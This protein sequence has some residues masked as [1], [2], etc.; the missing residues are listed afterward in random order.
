MLTIL[1]PQLEL[2]E[3]CFPLP[4]PPTVESFEGFATTLRHS[5][6]CVKMKG[7]AVKTQRLVSQ[8][9]RWLS[10]VTCYQCQFSPWTLLQ[11][12]V[13][14]DTKHFTNNGKLTFIAFVQAGQDLSP[15]YIWKNWDIQQQ[16]NFAEQSCGK[17]K[18]KKKLKPSLSTSWSSHELLSSIAQWK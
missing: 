3:Q 1:F 17:L 7:R 11:G 8:R 18:G 9:G 6:Q 13:L 4:C 10:S 16:N 2:P 14:G 5:W 12:F 15:Q